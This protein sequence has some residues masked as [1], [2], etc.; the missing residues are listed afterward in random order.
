LPLTICDTAFKGFG[1]SEK[2]IRNY[3]AEVWRDQ[4]IAF[5]EEVV[6]PHSKSSLPCVLA[7]NSLGGYAALSATA[8]SCT[9]EYAPK[10][11]IGAFALHINFS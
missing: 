2:P 10:N 11:L 7:G 4:L 1:L 5:I 6:M 3:N 9:S 8:L